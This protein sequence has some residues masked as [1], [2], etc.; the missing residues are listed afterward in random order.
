MQLIKKWNMN[1]FMLCVAAVLIAGCGNGGG[2]HT[3]GTGGTGGA[4]GT[5]GTGGNTGAGAPGTL[6]VVNNSQAGIDVVYIAPSSMGGSAWGTIR[7]LG[8]PLAVGT[9]W[10]ITTLAPDTY[11]VRVISTATASIYD[12]QKT[13]FMINATSPGAT[14]PFVD[15]DF[16]GTLEI[17]NNNPTGNITAI[18]IS[19]AGGVGGSLT[20]APP[21][22]SGGG[23]GQ[24]IYIPPGSYSV[25]V[26]LGGVAVNAPGLV[27]ISAYSVTPITFN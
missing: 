18:T 1:W 22:G 10:T 8:K 24:I 11:D 25:Q 7:N 14:V 26:M 20:L 2:F 19:T 4:G 23:V 9:T 27:N 17:T 15:A 12:A 5:G 16:S 3:T 6:T 21:I 13:N